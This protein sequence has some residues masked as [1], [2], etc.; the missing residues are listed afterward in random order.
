ME[1]KTPWFSEWKD[2][3]VIYYHI[4]FN[5]DSVG[6]LYE[7]YSYSVLKKIRSKKIVLNLFIQSIFCCLFLYNP[8]PFS[9]V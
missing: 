9:N 7:L 8:V 5:P 3:G 2:I 1:I 4:H 6:I